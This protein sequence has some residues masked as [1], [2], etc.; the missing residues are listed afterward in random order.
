MTCG[1]PRRLPGQ[2][3]SKR[4]PLEPR[5]SSVTKPKKLR[6]IGASGRSYQPEAAVAVP[7]E[8]RVAVQIKGDL[9]SATTMNVSNFAALA[10]AAYAAS[11]DAASGL[12]SL[13]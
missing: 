12:D 5:R 9:R 13:L 2:V 3:F 11:V 1:S 10:L 4:K 6:F 8:R 7:H